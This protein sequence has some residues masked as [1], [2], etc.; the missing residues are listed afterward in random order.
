MALTTYS[1]LKTSIASWLHRTDLT[2][3][4]PDFVTLAEKAFGTGPEAIK[5]PRMMTRLAIT[6]DAEYEAVPSDM[7]GIVSLTLTTNTDIYPLDNVTP[8]SL[9]FLRATTDIQAAFPRSFAMV[10]DDFRYSPVPD[11]AYTGELAYYA[12]I[13]ALSDSNASNW[14]L[15]NYPNVY[16]YGSLLQAA[17]YLV[18]DER[19]GLWQQLYQTALAGLIASER[20][21]QGVM[22]TPQF[23]ANDII[24]TRRASFNITQGY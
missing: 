6:V 15:A 24:P 17:P 1:E 9:A 4:I 11:Q 5:S 10:G 20:R 2:S 3:V 13:P 23:T 18:D 19:V 8:E 22:F 21:R 7:V 14:V 16:L 12:A